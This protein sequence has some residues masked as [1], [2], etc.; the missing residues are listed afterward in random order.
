M[1]LSMIERLRHVQN[2]LASVHMYHEA[3]LVAEIITEL[4]VTEEMVSR[5]AALS[6]SGRENDP[7][8]RARIRA[9]LR[10]ALL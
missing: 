5:G 1:S 4:Y 6:T 3:T 8:Y 7:A 9:I 2:K 10:A